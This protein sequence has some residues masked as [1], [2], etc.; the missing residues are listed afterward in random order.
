MRFKYWSPFVLLFWA[1][2]CNNATV[3]TENKIT[4]ERFPVPQI[5]KPNV[6]FWKKIYAHY[7]EREIIIHDSE[8]LS[9]VYEVV[10]LDSL[11][12][13]I[14]VSERLQ[15][16]KIER[17]KKNYKSLLLNLSKRKILRI[18][19]LTG[20]EKYIAALF[21]QQLSKDRL[22]RAA[23]NVRAQ[24]GLKERFEQG[25]AR[26]SLFL[27]KMREIFLSTGLPEELLVL[28]HV[29]SSFNYKAY[30]KMG[31]A[32]IWQFTRSTGRS[33]M[34][35]NYTVDERLDP[36]R[37]TEAAAKLLARN[38]QELGS[39][40]LAIT[41]YNHGL[42]GMKKARR[43]F[44]ND[45]SKI[46]KYYKSRS[47]KF[48]SR[49]FYAEF[50]A[51]LEVAKNYKTY[52]GEV[53]FL[54]PVEY[55]EFNIPH[56]ITVKT[57]IKNINMNLE[58]FSKLNPALRPPVLRSRR[59]I[60]KNFIVRLPKQQNLDIAELYAKISPQNKYSEQVRP[61]SHI[62]MRGETLSLIARKYRL[63]MD[64]I[65]AYNDIEN[66]HLIYVG[67][68][69][70]IPSKEKSR[71]Q[72]LK[73]VGKPEIEKEIKL[74]EATPLTNQA[75]TGMLDVPQS[76]PVETFYTDL[77]ISK[78]KK[79]I[80]SRSKPSENTLLNVEY[81][82][83]KPN[84][85]SQSLILD[86]KRLSPVELKKLEERFATLEE[87]MAMALPEFHV[88]ISKN[89]STRIVRSPYIEKVTP[90][91]REI[92]WPENGQVKV[93][94]DE[95]L[96]HFADWLEVTTQR[97]REINGLSYW[98]PIQ[99]GQP[100]WLTFEK[101]TPEEFHR[102]RLEYHQGIEEDFY[103]SFYVEGVQMYKVKAG[104][105]IW[106]ISNRVF[107]IPYWLIKKYNTQQNLSQLMAGQELVIPIVMAKDS[108]QNL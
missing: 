85:K 52:F 27:P 12:R 89:F 18:E 13:G 49:N 51:A 86:E 4:A 39:W 72:A 11:F 67:Q 9:I 42:N 103:N 84:T 108:D 106:V 79:S 43:K 29:E 71:R 69:L 33:Y 53:E 17:I 40:P 44:G 35:I 37:S 1:L 66:A 70:K 73:S 90:I 8:D 107:E 75:N 21:G 80:D 24:N 30:S 87:E 45:F 93:E 55:L 64:D 54:S 97:L 50:L 58:E 99:I 26:S 60:P 19:Y 98:Q 38:F 81:L 59:R 3:A 15:W 56:Y 57:L 95:T 94:P 91:Y 100:I 7:S 28:P 16:K 105:N 82:D 20:K 5:I 88:E 65:L 46:L 41:A 36:I 22:R 104:E 23:K 2:F 96:G 76:L 62:V 47:F 92:D 61:E 10:H 25:L 63:S 74:A 14:Q 68:N 34:K 6:E 32:G 31:A 101:V 48:A 102:R 77:R 83:V 78:G